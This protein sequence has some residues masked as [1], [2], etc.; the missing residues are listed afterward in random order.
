MSVRNVSQIAM[1]LLIVHRVAVA[2]PTIGHR[3]SALA[4]E[5]EELYQ[6]EPLF[7]V[8]RRLLIADLY[9]ADGIAQDDEHA[10]FLVRV[11]L[12]TVVI[13]FRA[14]PT[15]NG[16]VVMPTARDDLFCDLFQRHSHG[17]TIKRTRASRRT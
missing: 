2:T 3:A 15:T 10:T 6:L 12:G 8:E 7:I 9:R 11:S 16:A 14:A 13:Q 1:R 4:T 5:T 17:N